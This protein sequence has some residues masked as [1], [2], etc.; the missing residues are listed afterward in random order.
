MTIIITK[1]IAVL[2]SVINKASVDIF[3][4]DWERYEQMKLIEVADR[5]PDNNVA[6]AGAAA[7]AAA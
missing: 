2:L 3:I 4:M 7:P 1:L 5:K 6:A